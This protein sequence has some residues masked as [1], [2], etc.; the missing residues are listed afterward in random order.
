MASGNCLGYSSPCQRLWESGAFRLAKSRGFQGV[1]V[2]VDC[3]G[4]DMPRKAVK[5]LRVYASARQVLAESAKYGKPYRVELPDGTIRFVRAGSNSAAAYEVIRAVGGSVRTCTKVD[6]PETFVDNVANL[7]E[8]A[9][10]RI[11]AAL[12]KRISGRKKRR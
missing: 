1:V 10:K 6:D 2:L 12:Q 9:Q 7:P 8:A 5:K 4:S 3:R 11:M